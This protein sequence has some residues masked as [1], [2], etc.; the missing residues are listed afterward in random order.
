MTNKLASLFL[1]LGLDVAMAVGAES[2]NIT[3][4]EI[5]DHIR[6]GWTGMLIGGIEGLAHEFNYI[7]RPRQ[8]SE[9]RPGL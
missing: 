9:L 1:L 4:D 5:L 7:Q 8:D 6:G 2:T 3:R